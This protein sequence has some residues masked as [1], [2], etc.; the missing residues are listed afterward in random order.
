MSIET[1]TYEVPTATTVAEAFARAADHLEVVGLHQGGYYPGVGDHELFINEVVEV[2]DY[3]R[4]HPSTPCCILGALCAVALTTTL[5]MDSQ[6]FL[7]RLGFRAPRFND[8]PGRTTTEVT[9]RL[10]EIASIAEA[11]SC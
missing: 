4:T 10:R 1:S 3:L 2:G 8:E 11:A 5:A 9:S 7:D 6:S